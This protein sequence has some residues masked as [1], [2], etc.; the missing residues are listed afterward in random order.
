MRAKASYLAGLWEG[1]YVF[2]SYLVCLLT[3]DSSKAFLLA[4]VASNLATIYRT[5]LEF[6][7]SRQ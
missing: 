2:V 3:L 5:L 4:L 6:K 7:L 1:W